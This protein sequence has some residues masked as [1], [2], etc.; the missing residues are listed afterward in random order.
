MRII[1]RLDVKP[2]YVVKPI[3]FEGLR[4]ID[5]PTN[6]I[7]KYKDA[8]E[9][10]FIDIVSSLYNREIQFD[11]IRES[12]KNIFI[13]FAIGGG[14]KDVNDAK[15][16]IQNG[17][18]KVVLNTSVL[19]NPKLI[20]DIAK[21]F[22]SQAVAIHIQA[23]K[24]D[25]WYECYSEC[26]RERSYK[27]VLEWVKEVEQLGA[28]EILLSVIDK[29]GRKRG[30]DIE[31]SQKVIESVNIPVIIGS[32]AGKKE[33][34]LEVAKLNPS[35]IALASILHYDISSIRE[36]KE[37]LYKNNIKVSL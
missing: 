15:K 20:T 7:D 26:G 6:L 25:N 31:I 21:H 36:I 30:F 18:D 35:G 11:L 32:G 8:D 9:V 24:W 29:D 33:D 22:G 37:Y 3:H 23:K 16:L 13:P 19:K 4:K 5:I 34:I 12:A 1:A 27:N 2:P 10:F 28:G 17:A 14:I